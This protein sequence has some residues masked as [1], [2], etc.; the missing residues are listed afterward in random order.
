M[1]KIRKSL[2][3]VLAMLFV[4]STAACESGRTV[5]EEEY[6]LLEKYKRLDEIIEVIDAA[7]LW[8]YDTDTLMEGAALG[9]IGALGDPYSFY[10][11][12]GDVKNDEE[13]I[14]GEY[15]GLGIE[16]FGNPNDMTLTVRRVFYGSP[17]QMAGMRAGDKIIEIEGEEMTAYDLARAVELMRGEIGEEVSLKVYREGEP[18]PLELVCERAV[19]VTEIITSE[20]LEED[21]LGYIRIHQFEGAMFDQLVE[22]RAELEAAGIEGLILD[23]RDNPG[24]FINLAVDLADVFLDD[25]LVSTTEDRYGRTLEYFTKEGA[26]EIPLVVIVNGYSASASEI[27][28]AALR[29]HG[30]AKLVGETTYGKGIVQTVFPFADKVSAMQLTTNYWLTPNGERIHEVG[31][32]PD[33]EVELSEDAVDDNFMLIKEKDNQLEAAREELLKIIA[34]DR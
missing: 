3:L 14:T 30:V 17:A 21:K 26:W 10:H 4:V 6:K 16:V 22:A 28:A 29:D 33:V 31:V 5:T 1:M 32:A 2:L 8:D 9:M 7:Y 20:V 19:I 13:A 34:G 15:G 27:V 18:E 12:A 24:G 23:L 25:A 11:T